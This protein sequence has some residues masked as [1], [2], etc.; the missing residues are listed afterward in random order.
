MVFDQHGNVGISKALFPGDYLDIRGLAL[1][2]QGE[3][4]EE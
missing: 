2:V 3:C 4:D 1:E